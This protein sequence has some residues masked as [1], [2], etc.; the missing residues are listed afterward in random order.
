MNSEINLSN[1]REARKELAELETM[2]TAPNE[3][4]EA[5]LELSLRHVYHHLNFCWNIRNIETE[6]YKNMSA[7]EFIDWG[8][9]PNGFDDPASLNED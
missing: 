2:L 6:H 7:T 1:L 9:Y 8:K 4:S 5:E 3:A